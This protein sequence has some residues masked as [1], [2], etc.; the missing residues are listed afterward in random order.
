MATAGI[1][2]SI[3][4]TNLQELQDIAGKLFSSGEKAAILKAAIEKA[5]APALARL[6]EITPVGPTGNLKRAATKKVVGY[7]KNGNAVGLIGY[8][9]A[10]RSAS[11]SAAGGRVRRGADRAFHQWW[12]E[13]GTQD[14]VVT[15]L[16]NTPYARKGHTRR[17]R[18][19]GTTT[20]RPH[21][22]SGQNAVIASSYAKLGPFKFV[23]TQ[24][25]QEGQRVQTDPG[26]PQA[27]FK[28][29]PRG[30]S[31]IRIPAMQAGGQSG[32]PPLAAA[33]AD[34][35]TTVAEILQRELRI[36]IERALSALTQSARGS[37][38]L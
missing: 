21:Q 29:A 2:L 5:I 3:E 9:R 18:S 1:T 26:S 30:A 11:E 15:K 12:L 17:T 6:K 32:R 10:G 38:E 28:K 7:T 31:V 20:V 25:S 19:G 24:R 27:F 16:S 34:T 23:P 35:K 4:T 14:R 36:S 8:R 37:V 33:W 13:Y 22:V